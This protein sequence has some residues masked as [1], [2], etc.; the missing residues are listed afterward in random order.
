MADESGTDPGL[1]EPLINEEGMME[2][3]VFDERS[4]MTVLHA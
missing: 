2:F 3:P 1:F 4:A